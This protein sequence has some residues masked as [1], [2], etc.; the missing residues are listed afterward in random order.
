MGG[1]FAGR[2]DRANIAAPQPRFV[3]PAKAGTQ[4]EKAR[5]KR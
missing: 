2:R 4:R 1:I 5:A 3:I